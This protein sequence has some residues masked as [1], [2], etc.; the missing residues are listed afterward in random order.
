MND[1]LLRIY[2]LA[3]AGVSNVFGSPIKPPGPVFDNPVE[4][5]GKIV[6]TIVGVFILFAA[7]AALIYLLWG[8]VE[9]VTSGG[10][11]EKLEKARLRMTHAAFGIII[12]IAVT[13]IFTVVTGDI[14]GIIRRDNEGKW[15]FELPTVNSCVEHGQICVESSSVCCNGPAE[16]CREDPVGS[17]YKCQ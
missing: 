13:G 6:V 15:R 11:Q 9:W 1:L 3:A 16:T 7:L 17:G 4:G 12:L 14:L 5:L 2:M 8:A 10:E